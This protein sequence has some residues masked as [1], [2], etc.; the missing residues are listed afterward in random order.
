MRVREFLRSMTPAASFADEMLTDLERME[1]ALLAHCAAGEALSGGLERVV[2]SGGK[3]LRPLLAWVCWHLAGKNMEIIP[4]MA[5]LEL[6]HTASLIHDD[7]VDGA[8]ARRAVPTINAREGAAQAIR[9]GDLL[10]GWAMTYLK[11]YRGTGINEALSEVSWQ[12][13]LGELEQR[14]DLFRAADMT[15]ARYET[16]IQRKTALL[17]AESCACGAIA[18]GADAAVTAA[19]RSYGLHLGMAFQIRDDL[20]DFLP[21]H[22]DGKS[23]LQDLRSGVITLPMLLAMQR[24]P[25]LTAL[26]ERREKDEL[27]IE[28]IAARMETVGA[29]DETRDALRRSCARAAEALALL[30]QSAEKQSLCM[31]ATSL[32]E[33]N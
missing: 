25:E 33:V 16:R 29:L 30:P 18:G 8:C 24:A 22:S 26:L 12:M 27:T 31:L 32:S 20:C 28:R 13:C 4:L 23:P 2:S 19:L 10:L 3:R 5:M 7:V 15:A 1:R 9:S 21:Q 17:M 14:E 6:M 11:R